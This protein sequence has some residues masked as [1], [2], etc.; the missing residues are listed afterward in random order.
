[1]YNY[2]MQWPR[3]SPIALRHYPS[4]QPFCVVFSN[5]SGRIHYPHGGL[6]VAISAPVQSKFLYQSIVVDSNS[7]FF[8]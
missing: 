5:G 4:G 1:M 8:S 6:A 2:S 7:K 3:G